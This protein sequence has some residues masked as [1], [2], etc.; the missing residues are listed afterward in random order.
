MSEGTVVGLQPWLPW[1][2][3]RWRWWTEP[4]RAERLA[5]LR[6]GL[7]AVLLA[8]VLGSYGP[9]VGDFFT[10]AGLGGPELFGYYCRPPRFHWSL[11]SGVEDVNVLR[12]AVAAWA[13]ATACLLVGLLTR[14]SAAVAWLLSTSFANLN[15]Y[16]DNGGDQVR[17]IALFY[18]MLCPCGAA[19]SV[20]AWARR[21]RGG[22]A[23]PN[24]VAPWPLRLLF[25][26]MVWI[27]FSNGAFKL[28]GADWPRGEALYYVL[29]DLTLARWSYAQ[30][31]L[32]AAI[33]TAMT[34][35]VLA[36]EVSFP[37]LVLWRPTRVAALVL[38][39]LFHVG[40][41]LSLELGGFAF[42]MLCLYLPL[43][44]WERLSDRAKNGPRS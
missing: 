36:W 34:Y 33:T 13:A 44:P 29:G 21:R 30:V 43:L 16:I 41:G 9:H 20:D 28:M 27:Y 2:L 14:P 24:Y 39:V 42:Y 38:G 11:L 12:A 5:A 17:G 19:W 10:G 35:T 40:I 26:Q 18:L 15:P 32:P 22:P 37:L 23:G 31:P 7:A 6:I 3:S 25:V 1:P 4:V 8:D